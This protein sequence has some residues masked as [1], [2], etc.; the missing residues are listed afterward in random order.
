MMVVCLTANWYKNE[1]DTARGS[2][3]IALFATAGTVFAAVTN[4]RA[5]LSGGNE[6]PARET[7]AD[8]RAQLQVRPSDNEIRYQLKVT[9]IENVVAAHIHLGPPG[10]NGSIVAFLYGPAAPGGGPEHGWIA[11]GTITAADLIGP[12]AG[13]PLE[14]IRIT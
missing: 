6:V 3:V 1:I 12:L 4:W 10:A 2:G 11:K 13:Q 8:G 7:S 9:D 14:P 5:H